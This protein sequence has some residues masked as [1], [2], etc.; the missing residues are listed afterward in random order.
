MAWAQA[1]HQQGTT[2]ICRLTPAVQ[3]EEDFRMPIS[4]YHGPL[5]ISAKGLN[6]SLAALT[7][8]ARP[9]AVT[10]PDHFNFLLDTLRAPFLAT[11]GIRLLQHVYHG[12]R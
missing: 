9:W 3:A 7:V 5:E 8:G 1:I 11:L 6:V 4:G 12:I 10:V 2:S